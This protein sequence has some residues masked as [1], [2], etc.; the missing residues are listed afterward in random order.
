MPV[1]VILGKRLL[2][3]CFLKDGS[4]AWAACYINGSTG[5]LTSGNFQVAPGQEA[6]PAVV[7]L[8][9]RA[10]HMR[11][12]A[13]QLETRS[14]EAFFGRETARADTSEPVLLNTHA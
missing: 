7:A 13:K 12:P 6:I 14:H 4:L 11:L 2:S 9:V 5:L 10:F 8:D 3:S 1:T